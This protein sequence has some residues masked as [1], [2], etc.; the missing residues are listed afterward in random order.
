MT[1]IRFGAPERKTLTGAEL[2]IRAFQVFSLLPIPYVLAI[3]GYPAI[4]TTDNIL[5]FLFGVGLTSIPRAEA[6][7]L[8]VC[9]R[10]SLSE[11]AVVAILLAAAV[12]CGIVIRRLL[13]RDDGSTVPLR[14][15]YAAWIA[16]DLVLRLIPMPFNLAFGIVAQLIGFCLRLACLALVVLDLRE[17]GKQARP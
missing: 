10:A 2:A 5:S 14:R 13:A 3:V 11:V 17:I 16:L 1:E 15:A 9:Y 6:L 12:V 8:S 4:I 7:L